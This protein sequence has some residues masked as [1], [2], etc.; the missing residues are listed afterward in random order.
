MAIRMI[1]YDM[2]ITIERAEKLRQLNQLIVRISDYIFQ[3]SRKVRKGVKSIMGGNILEL[4]SEKLIAKG[5]EKGL[6]NF[7][8][9]T[10]QIR[11]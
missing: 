10:C 2:V 5:K 1:E 3:N 7:L 4:E 11:L 8:N 9:V 6:H